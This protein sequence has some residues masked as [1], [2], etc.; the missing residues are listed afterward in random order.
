MKLPASLLLLA[1]MGIASNVQAEVIPGQF[2]VKINKHKSVQSLEDAGFSIIKPVIPALGIYLVEAPIGIESLT[3][4]KSFNAIESATYEEEV[5]LRKAKK[6]PNDPDFNQQWSLETQ[7]NGAD[8]NI[9]GVWQKSVGSQDYVVAVVDEGVDIS[10]RDLKANLWTNTGEIPGNGIDDDNNGYIDDVHGWNAY[11]SN[12]DLIAS[13]H[14][15]HVAGIVGARGDN[16]RDVT[17]VNWNVKIMGISAS[18]ATTSVVLEGYG[19]VLAQKQRWLD[20]NG[21]YG[22]NV[23]ATNSSFGV[24]RARCENGDYRLWNDVYNAMGE[25][26]ILSAAA[27]IN[28]QVN[29]DQMGDVPTGCSSPYLVTVTN[30]TIDNEKYQY[31]G[32]GAVGIDLGAPGTDI[33]SLLPGNRTGNLTGTS[34]ATP[35]VA[36]AIA[37]LYAA[38]DGLGEAAKRDPGATAL[39]VKQALLEGSE[40]LPSLRGKTVSGG[41][42]NVQGSY[43]ILSAE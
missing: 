20:S 19:Y 9:S 40:K 12:G 28:D 39:R 8:I 37:L 43:Q 32:Y 16:N 18:S 11:E 25:A 31:A 36:G 15:T 38:V 7:N 10:H 1:L 24:D 14:G 13:R 26:G 4:L 27:T 17:G 2:V 30:T 34:M 41:K 23:V 42:L 21:A 3:S 5:T 33:L 35:H 29:I 22:A 6:I